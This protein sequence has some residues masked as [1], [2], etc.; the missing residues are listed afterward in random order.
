MHVLQR[1]AQDVLTDVSVDSCKKKR[2]LATRCTCV[3]VCVTRWNYEF[4]P[5]QQQRAYHIPGL[6]A[7]STAAVARVAAT[8][9]AATTPAA[10]NRS[11]S[12]RKQDVPGSRSNSSSRRS[13]TPAE[14]QKAPILADNSS[15]S[16][17]VT[18]I[19]PTLAPKTHFLCC[20]SKRISSELTTMLSMGSG[21]ACWDCE[22]ASDPRSG[23]LSR[24]VLQ[25]GIHPRSA[26][27]GPFYSHLE[28]TSSSNGTP[29][30]LSRY[31]ARLPYRYR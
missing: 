9:A 11:S 23:G 8:N 27:D 1:N 20:R 17:H 13:N 15:T 10:G 5:T 30:P 3:L 18:I 21:G 28:F 22:D 4:R 31:R 19:V 12:N 2:Q 7:A 29:L 6:A 16:T 26:G 24:N 25:L 14:Q